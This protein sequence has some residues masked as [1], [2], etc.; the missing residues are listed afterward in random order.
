MAV[1]LYNFIPACHT[2]NHIKND[3]GANII[4]PY[5]ES[6]FNANGSKD[7]KFRAAL[8]KTDV[9]NWSIREI[10]NINFH[11]DLSDCQDHAKK[12]RIANSINTFHL[13]EIYNTHQIEIKDLFLRY[14]NYCH[15]KRKDILRLFYKKEITKHNEK[16]IDKILSIH[17]M[18]MKKAFLGFPL[19]AGASQY[20]LRKFKED[21]IEQL[22]E[23]R[24]RMKI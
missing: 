14:S 16:Q 17:A 11:I 20:P 2:C 6:F 24:K 7:G 13:E 1:S 4:Y 19:G 15:P 5:N 21:I 9:T 10:K 18:K 22:D 3:K 23:T 8:P 12:T